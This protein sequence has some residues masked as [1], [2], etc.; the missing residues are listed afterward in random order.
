MQEINSNIPIGLNRIQDITSKTQKELDELMNSVDAPAF[1]AKQIYKWIQ[2]GATIDE[3]TNVPLAL[4]EDLK[5]YPFGGATIIETLISKKDGTK[6]F[7]FELDDGEIV[8][9]VLMHYEYGNTLCVSTQ[10]GCNMHCSFCAST[11]NGRVRNMTAGEILSC[12][13]RVNRVYAPEEKCERGVTNVVLMGSGE[14]LDNYENVL[15]FLQNVS[16]PGGINISPRNISLSTCGIVERMHDLA[17]DAPH[18]TLSVSLHAPND[19]IRKRIMPIAN[20]YTMN[21][22]LYGANNYAKVTG[23]RVIFEYALIDGVNA[24]YEN[25]MELASRLRRIN[26]HVNLIPLNPIKGNPLSGVTREYADEFAKWLT[27]K[28]VSATIRREM[29][30]DIEGACGQLRRKRI[31]EKGGVRDG[32]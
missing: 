19:E 3:M 31:A 2:S 22:V 20:R 18:V 32:L 27:N 26:C 5:V 12:V 8:E 7:I 28:G 9:G 21:E 10:V 17:I 16:A 29:G 25:A 14:P 1:R 4:R 30:A 24:S 13:T 11:I 23:R 15:R 6:K